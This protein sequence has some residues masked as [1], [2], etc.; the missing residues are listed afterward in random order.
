MVDVVARRRSSPSPLR[1]PGGKSSLADFFE[2][3]IN[4]LGLS[5][6][7]YLEPYAGG[8]G[9]GLD[10]LYRGVVGRIVINDLDKSIYS[11]WASMLNQTDD[12]L[13][14]LE[15]TPLTVDEWKRQREIYRRRD[16][17]TVDPLDLG[18]ATFYLNRTN[19]SGVLGGGMIGG[20]KQ[21][22]TY[23][24]DARFN[25]TTLRGRIEQLAGHR[26]KIQVT[27]QDGVV[28]LRHWLPKRNVFAYVDPPYYE[29][30]SFLYLNS[31]SDEQHSS[32]A[33]ELN[34]SAESNW[35]LT[36]D[37]AD[38]IENL[39]RDRETLEFDLRY[40]AHRCEVASEL[41]VLSDAVASAFRDQVLR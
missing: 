29:K 31:F 11:I 28:R 2:R 4:A 18:F 13:H 17:E 19:R 3:A 33:E 5:E 14:R 12:F 37:K 21:A 36:Y 6:P 22:G 30:G 39:Y 34:G 27:H 41:M 1:Y 16:D 25:R 9:A 40:S 35:I 24:M 20:L 32:L 15:S 10:L 23:K 8:A 38:F 7:T 26:D